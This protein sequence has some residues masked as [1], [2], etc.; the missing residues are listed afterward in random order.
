MIQD[1]PTPLGMPEI[2]RNAM[3]SCLI[4]N[5]LNGYGS[6]EL[7]RRPTF[8]PSE[9][10]DLPKFMR[11]VEEYQQTKL[12]DDDTYF[13]ATGDVEDGGPIT[14]NFIAPGRS[15]DDV[16]VEVEDGILDVKIGPSS[17]FVG[18]T[19]CK[20]ITDGDMG[21]LLDETEHQFELINYY[22]VTSSTMLDGILTVTLEQNVPEHA[23]RRT[24]PIMSA[25]GAEA[26]IELEDQ[27][28]DKEPVT[29]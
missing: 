19:V 3:A 12:V 10:F 27:T 26:P 1:T 29:A 4:S 22:E 24:I 9:P 25:D 20:H 18:V 6:L 16:T 11:D 5:P 23:K 14:L 15:L 7:F 17:R 2:P 28:Q 13:F 8:T 21:N